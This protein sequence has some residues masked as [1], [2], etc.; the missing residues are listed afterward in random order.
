MKVLFYSTKGYERSY[1]E[2]AAKQ[3]QNVEFRE[4]ALSVH[5]AELSRGFDVVSIFT[6]DD[7]STD[8]V[9]LLNKYG[10]RYI[11][12]RAA[13]YDNVDLN[14]AATLGM[15]VANV[16]AYSPYAIA[17]HA[18]AMILALNRKLIVA[19]TQVHR[20]DFTTDKLVGFDLHGKTIGIIGVGRIG[21]ILAGIM[22]G[23]GCM[24]IGYDIRENE[25]LKEK[26]G[27]EY[28]DLPA[29]CRESD[30]ISIHTG[31]S[32]ATRHMLDKKLIRLMKQGVMLINTGRGGC[33]DTADVITALEDGHIGYFGMDVYENE[34]GI[35]FHD[36]SGKELKDWMLDMLMTMPNVLITPHQ[37]FATREALTNIAT[38]TFY[39]IACWKTQQPC[40]N[41]LIHPS[42]TPEVVTNAEYEE[43]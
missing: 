8:V 41:D 42:T 3:P 9:E 29:L 15:Q 28:V 33:I 36:H 5:T 38:T 10:V 30:I 39:N 22:H 21:G 23:F 24:V 35:F 20:H 40:E 11:A 32:P 2:D 25:E 34:K 13:G 17:E 7:C 18:V 27:L 43:L 26:Y 4:E 12:V 31:L 1:L 37:A 19:D 6:G 16:P 14:K